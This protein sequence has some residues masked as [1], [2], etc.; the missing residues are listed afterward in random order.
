[1]KKKNTKKISTARQTGKRSRKLEDRSIE[2]SSL[3]NGVE[4]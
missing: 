2:M 1:M 4:I 3:K